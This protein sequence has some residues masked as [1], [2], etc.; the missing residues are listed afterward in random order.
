MVQG[1]NQCRFYPG[2]R[3][4][5]E[6][7]DGNLLVDRWWRNLSDARKAAIV[8]EWL[9]RSALG[10]SCLIGTALTAVRLPGTWWILA[11]SVIYLWALGWPAST[12]WVLGVLAGAAVVGELLELA[13]SFTLAKRAGASSWASWGGVLGGI[14]GAIFLTFLIPVPI[15]GTIVGAI[16]GCFLGAASAEWWVRR[17]VVQGTRVGFFAIAGFALGMAVKVAVA[18]IMSAILLGSTMKASP[19]PSTAGMSSFLPS[20]L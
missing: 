12:G 19:V 10:L 3:V 1:N 7:G 13:A 18:L 6:V 16:T 20:T 17:H 15:V 14:L 4:A 2:A 9:V 5:V 8:D 11:T